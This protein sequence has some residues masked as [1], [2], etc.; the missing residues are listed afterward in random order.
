M[1][2]LFADIVLEQL[3]G[4]STLDTMLGIKSLTASEATKTLTIKFK[5]KGREGINTIV[6]R[7]DP[8][9]T[10][11]VEFWDIKVSPKNLRVLKVDT[12]SDVYAD[13]LVDVC[14]SRTGL[15]LR[16]PKVV[17]PR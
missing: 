16:I 5:A 6:I 2:S 9:D 3:G 1:S 11:T 17:F 15:A 13:V 10:Y 8:S 7:L 4:R 14:E 12:V